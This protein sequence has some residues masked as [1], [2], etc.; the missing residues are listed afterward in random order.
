[1]ANLQANLRSRYAIALD[2]LPRLLNAVNQPFFESTPDDRYATLFL[3]VYDNVTRQLEY[4]NCG[5]NAPLLFRTNGTIERLHSTSTVIG[6]S[7]NWQCVTRKVSLAPGD[8]LVIYTT[9]SPRPT[10]LP[11]TNLVKLA[12]SISSAPTSPSHP[13]SSSPKSNPP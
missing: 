3:A 5:H 9:A 4:A 8:L 10:T 11:A 13:H 1:M 6:M 12:S 2:D 7:A